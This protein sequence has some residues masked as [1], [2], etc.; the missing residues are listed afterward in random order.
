MISTRIGVD[1]VFYLKGCFLTVVADHDR[2]GSVVWA[3]EGRNADTLKAFYDGLGEARRAALEVVSLDLGSAYAQATDDKVS[4]VTQCVDPFHVVKL[5]NKTIDEAALVSPGPGMDLHVA[6]DRDAIARESG[7]DGLLCPSRP[8]PATAG[9]WSR[10]S[11]R[12]CT[13][14][15]TVYS[16][17]SRP[18]AGHNGSC[19][20]GS[21]LRLRWERPGSPPRRG[22]RSYSWD[23][24]PML[25]TARERARVANQ[26]AKP[27]LRHFSR[28]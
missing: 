4:H 24:L 19:G 2:N 10:C 18:R 16:R 5:A 20:S 28:I 17:C 21:P 25:S 27:S 1:E 26:G 22:P 11:L 13:R 23:H 14:P 7:S 15:V 6:T 12:R 9:P 3:K 8:N